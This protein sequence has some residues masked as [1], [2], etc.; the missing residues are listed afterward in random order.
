MQGRSDAAAS[1]SEEII[2]SFQIAEEK[3]SKEPP[4]DNQTCQGLQHRPSIVGRMHQALHHE[5]EIATSADHEER[6]EA[7]QI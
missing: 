1:A 6:E 3:E 5:L 2:G 4:K 7:A